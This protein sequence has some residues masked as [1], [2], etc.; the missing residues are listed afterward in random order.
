VENTASLLLFTAII[1]QWVYMLIE[2]KIAI[3]QLSLN[4]QSDFWFRKVAY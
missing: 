2:T 1:Y 4:T 3:P